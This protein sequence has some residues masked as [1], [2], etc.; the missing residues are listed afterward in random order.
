L[1]FIDVKAWAADHAMTQTI[2]VTARNLVLKAV[3]PS[4][5]S[6]TTA[7]TSILKT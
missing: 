7:R 4:S 6:I 5:A 3:V 2:V 1:S